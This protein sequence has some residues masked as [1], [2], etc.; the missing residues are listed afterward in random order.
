MFSETEIAFMQHALA[1]AAK[2]RFT[3]RPNP[4]VGAVLVK[5]NQIIGE[6][7][8]V[9]CGQMHAEVMALQRAA[10]PVGAT[11]YVTLEP[12]I[13][14]GRTAPCVDALI[15]A[16]ISRVVV[17]MPDPNPLVAGQG[18]IKLREQGITVDVGLLEEAAQQLNLGFISRFKRGRPYVVA[19][20]AMSLDGRIAM[21]SGESQ[22][23]TGPEAR[24]QVQ[25]LRAESGAIITG[26]NTV[27]SD[28]PR[29][30]VRSEAVL[31]QIENDA[32]FQPPLRVVLDRSKRIPSD[33]EILSDEAPTWHMTAQQDLQAVLHELAA[34]EVNQVLIEA[35]PQLMGAFLTENLV[36]ELVLFYAPKLLGHEGKPM[37]ILPNIA[38][39]A[40]HIPLKIQSIQ[41]VGPDICVRVSM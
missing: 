41:Q 36:D 20:I 18:I 26:A 8:H 11:C 6:G 35:G 40:Q 34:R 9:A 12:C 37:A 19:K 1:L 10:D 15:A 27:L 16:G 33:A 24:E 13:H 21:A 2:G 22:W 39:L 28:N 32:T 30:T 31:S 17:A 29:M 23:I 38:S 14:Q 3:A 5:D 7:Y 25:T 4:M